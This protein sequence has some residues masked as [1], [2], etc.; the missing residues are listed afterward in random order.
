MRTSS[1]ARHGFGQAGRGR[2]GGLARRLLLSATFIVAALGLV[3]VSPQATVLHDSPAEMLRHKTPPVPSPA[4]VGGA[5]PVTAL[6]AKLIWPPG[7]TAESY[8][9]TT[10]TKTATDVQGLLHGG[11]YAGRAFDVLDKLGTRDLIDVFKMLDRESGIVDALRRLPKAASF[12][13]VAGAAAAVKD[14][15]GFSLPEGIPGQQREELEAFR[16][17][18]Q[19]P[20]LLPR[21][22]ATLDETQE[23][24][25]DLIRREQSTIPVRPLE[26]IPK[27]GNSMG[28]YKY[29][30]NPD[31]DPQPTSLHGTD[32]RR[33]AVNVAVWSELGREGSTSSIN[34][35]DNQSAIVTWGRGFSAK[36]ELPE[37]MARLF[38]ADPAVRNLL[39]D[40]GFTL[41]D[42]TWLAVDVGS[43]KVKSGDEALNLVR[44]NKAVLSRLIDIAED[45]A[46]AQKWVDAQAAT[47]LRHA[48]AVPAAAERWPDDVIRF[49]AHSVHWGG[50]TWADAAPTGGDLKAI[51]QL[52]S[53][54]VRNTDPWVGGSRLVASQPTAMLLSMADGV[55]RSVLGPVEEAPP[56]DDADKTAL[57]GHIFFDAG[58]NQFFHLAP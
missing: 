15:D 17:V 57:S 40:A 43:G 6:P 52:Q 28:G 42:G 29:G 12:P 24:V 20:T 50:L 23:A 55:T 37:A 49:V 48:G 16:R 10:V 8:R 45:P 33:T 34:T 2:L 36:G 44:W 19:W 31:L 5:P 13:R 3:A 41:K 56:V 21:T 25:T 54:H 39:L 47:V 46:H 7:T 22:A 4:G 26:D 35:Y 1:Q 58:N 11:E 30:R 53:Q 9:F 51:I 14:P 32:V 38:A 27:S 18:R